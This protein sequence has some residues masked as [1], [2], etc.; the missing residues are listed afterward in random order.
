MRRCDGMAFDQEQCVLEIKLFKSNV[1]KTHVSRNKMLE[2]LPPGIPMSTPIVVAPLAAQVRPHFVSGL[3]AL[4]QNMLRLG[5][6]IAI[7]FRVVI[8]GG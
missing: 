1:T 8:S 4:E 6:R 5:S 2:P 7:L 3:P